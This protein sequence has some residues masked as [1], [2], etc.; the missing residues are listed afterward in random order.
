MDHQLAKII[1]ISKVT[2]LIASKRRIKISDA[3]DLFYNSGIIDFIDN[4]ET[5]LCGESPLYV[6]SLFEEEN[7][8]SQLK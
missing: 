4:D 5:G 7:T 6:L 1:L 8:Q 3:R 2:E